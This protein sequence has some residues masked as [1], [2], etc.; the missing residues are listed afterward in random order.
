MKEMNIALIGKGRWGANY[1]KAKSDLI[2]KTRD[3][4]DLFKMSKID[5]VIVA[6]PSDTHFTIAR[7]FIT[8]G[9]NVLIEKP[10]TKT[11]KEALVLQ[12]LHQK[13]KNQMVMAGHILMYDPG[14]Q[15]L[16]KS[17]AGV[18]KIKKL[19]FKASQEEQRT[20]SSILENWG[21][22]PIYMFTDIMGKSPNS[23]SNGR[24][25]KDNLN[26]TLVFDKNVTAHTDISISKVRQ[27]E[28]S[29]IGE[30]GK[31]TLD[32]AGTKTLTFEDTNN[33]KIDIEF[34]QDKSPLELEIAE[35][36]DSIK[37]HRETKT[38]LSQGVEVMRILE[39]CRN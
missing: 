36:I 34:P 25:D 26:L 11:Y 1:L 10:I 6:S 14:Y 30:K 8:R 5:G 38:P 31:L 2:V 23:V 21:P 13:H 19:K 12:K 17:L 37:K 35:F 18:G 33:R 4:P 3:Y 7:D 20:N 39:L 32:W 28:F 27:R 15:E 24:S 16:K 9:F 22:H 29:V